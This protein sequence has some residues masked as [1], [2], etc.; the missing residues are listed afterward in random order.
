MFGNTIS[1]QT[2]SSGKV[3][4]KSKRIGKRSI[5]VLVVEREDTIAN[6][7]TAKELFT[8]RKMVTLSVPRGVAGE[9]YAVHLLAME[10]D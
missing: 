3:R 4:D 6:T 7:V 9:L 2:E 10:P 1:T 5:V 8:T